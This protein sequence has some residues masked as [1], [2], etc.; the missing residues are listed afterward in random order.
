MTLVAGEQSAEVVVRAPQ[1]V[2]FTARGAWPES[3]RSTA[4]LP[5]L[6]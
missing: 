5:R 1:R 2:G 4:R 6:R 3:T